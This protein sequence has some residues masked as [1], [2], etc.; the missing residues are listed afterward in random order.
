MIP[1]TAKNQRLTMEPNRKHQRYQRIREQLLELL[2][3]T[4]DRTARM[5]SIV[6]L[7]HHKIDY[8]SWTG[9]YRLIDGKLLVG[10]YQGFLAC[11]NLKKDTG[12]CWAAV[13]QKKTIVVPDVNKFPGHIPCDGRSKSEIVVP[14]NNEQG[15]VFAVL[16]VDSSDYSSFDDVDAR[17]LENIV[18]LL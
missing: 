9:F 4:E 14:C 1:M 7:L 11:Q 10:P 16:D 5:A 2:T 13:N 8:F 15:D 6:A 18:K 12:V 3:V 17:E